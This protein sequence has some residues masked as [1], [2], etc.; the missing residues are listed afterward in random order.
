VA[1]CL[2]QHAINRELSWIEE[3]FLRDPRY[4]DAV[5]AIP[6]RYGELEAILPGSVPDCPHDT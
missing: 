3:T 2:L 5:H 4:L 6:F 1:N